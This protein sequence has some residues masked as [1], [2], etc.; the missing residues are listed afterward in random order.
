VIFV[1]NFNLSIKFIAKV[2]NDCILIAG[3]SKMAAL[4]FFKC[5]LSVHTCIV[6][7]YYI[8]FLPLTLHESVP[9]DSSQIHGYLFFN[10]CFIHVCVYIGE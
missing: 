10:Y 7:L 2:W 3:F 4:S 8:L 1:D 6:Y 9:T 5:F